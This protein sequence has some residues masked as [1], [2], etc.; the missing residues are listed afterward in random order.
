MSEHLINVVCEACEQDIAWSAH[1]PPPYICD[2]CKISFFD[3]AQ[4]DWLAVLPL[5]RAAIED[6]ATHRRGLGGE[7]YCVYCKAVRAL[8]ADLRARVERG[9]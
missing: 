1:V 9:E 7:C 6:E 5:V 2:E 3:R 4:A 8:P